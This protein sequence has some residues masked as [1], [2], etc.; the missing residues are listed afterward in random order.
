[1]RNLLRLIVKYYFILLFLFLE[2]LGMVLIFQFNPFHRSFVVNV[3]RVVR[4]NMNTRV[5]HVRDYLFLREENE[6]LNTENA[7]LRQQLQNTTRTVYVNYPDSGMADTIST[8]TD[9]RFEYIPAEVVSNS[10][11]KQYNYITL[12]KGIRDSV[13]SDMA[14]ISSVGVVGMVLNSSENFCTVQPVINRNSRIGAKIR[15]EDYFGIIE[16]D[17]RDPETAQLREIPIHV[18]IEV[19]DTIET[20]GYSSVFPKGQVIGTINEF[21]RPEGNFYDIQVS[22]FV[23]FRTLNHVMIVRNKLQSEQKQMETGEGSE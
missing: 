15:G 17:G 18:E 11:N 12:D 1:M 7:N 21:K 3:S 23:N 2:G 9:L 16:W 8:D 10:V 13:T 14:V 22:L 5:N 20:S 4:G 6:R 19:G